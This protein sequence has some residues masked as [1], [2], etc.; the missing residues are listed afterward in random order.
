MIFKTF[1]VGHEEECGQDSYGVVSYQ[2]GQ[3]DRVSTSHYNQ[4]HQHPHVEGKGK[5]KP[6][7]CICC[8]P[9][10]ETG[11]KAKVKVHPSNEYCQYVSSTISIIYTS[12]H[13]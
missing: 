4:A 2:F 6:S 13:N 7:L 8:H 5:L 3:S 11:L 9:I 10:I 1:V 12:M